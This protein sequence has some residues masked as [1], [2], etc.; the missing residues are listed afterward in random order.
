MSLD[1][2]AVTCDKAA[3]IPAAL[4]AVLKAAGDLLHGMTQRHDLYICSPV[5]RQHSTSSCPTYRV[6]HDCRT[7]WELLLVLEP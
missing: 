5:Q 2:M 7:D 4:E 3:G 6:S 1:C